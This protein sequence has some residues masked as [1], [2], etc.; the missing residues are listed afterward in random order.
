MVLIS[1]SFKFKQ[2]LAGKTADGGTKDI[3]IMVPLKYLSS[4]WRTLEMP[5]INCEIN[6]ILTW[7]DKHVLYSDIKATTFATTD[8]KLYVLVVTL[9]T[10]NKSKLLQQLKSGFKGTINWNK[11][12]SKVSIQVSNPYLDFLTDPSFQGVNRPFA[13]WFENTDD[14]KV[15]TKYYLPTL[16]IKDYNVMIDGQNFLDQPVKNNIRTCDNI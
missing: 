15:P 12:Q 2:K 4:F 16:E 14:R 10:Q 1:G 8:T 6:L 3:E 9:S 7:S 13:S 11:C 5:L